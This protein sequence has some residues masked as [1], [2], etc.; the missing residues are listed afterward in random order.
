MKE[1]IKEILEK[2]ISEL[3]QSKPSDLQ[4]DGLM[5][6]SLGVSYFL[7]C[8]HIK[9]NDDLTLVKL[10]EYLEHI[11]EKLNTGESTLIG[12]ASFMDGLSGLGY[13]TNFLEKNNLA[14][15]LSESLAIFDE[16]LFE[17]C[18]AFIKAD[19]YDFMNGSIGILHYFISTGKEELCTEIINILYD[20][21]T[22]KGSL[23]LYNNSPYINGL[24]IG[25]A[26]GIIGIAKV[27]DGFLTVKSQIIID[28]I[29]DFL[30]DI[31]ENK[32]PVSISGSNYFLPR[33]I[34][35]DSGLNWRPVLAWSNSDLNFS[36]LVLSMENYQVSDVML[37]NAEKIALESVNRTEEP[38]TRIW[39]SRL[40][41]GSAGVAQSYLTIN[42]KLNS[43]ILEKAYE[44]WIKETFNM[45]VLDNIEDHKYSF[46]NNMPGTLLVFEEYMDSKIAGWNKLILL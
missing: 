2:D 12:K 38:Q 32:A 10:E 16:F 23:F 30:Q 5:N 13:V 44:Y 25:Y 42:K 19:N 36:S 6:G 15:G 1:Q 11:I 9:N 37:K 39:D 45:Y 14:E 33:S 35:E 46:I 31:I 20:K 29:F 24:H 28:Y 26:H 18:K 22:E 7:A 40:F 43:P 8:L 34:H 27:L 17:S 3:L 21:Y 41:F 4:D